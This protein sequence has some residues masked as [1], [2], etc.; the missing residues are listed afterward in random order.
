MATVDLRQFHQTFFEESLEGLDGMEE[1][2]LALESGAEDPELVHTIFRA[3]HS[4]KGGAATFGFADLAAFTH[5]LESLLEE[6]RGGRRAADG[7]TVELL[8]QSVDCMRGMLARSRDGGAVAD[9]ASARIR[10]AA[11][12]PASSGTGCAASTTSMWRVGVAWP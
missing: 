2:L 5:V 8:L 4:I 9:A 3:A 12:R 1:A 7:E 6:V 11:R 10:S